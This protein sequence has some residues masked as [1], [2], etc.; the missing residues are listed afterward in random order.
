MNLKL[1]MK[2]FG[3]VINFENLKNFNLKNKK[4]QKNVLSLIVDYF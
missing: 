3:D 1:I 2:G 4:M